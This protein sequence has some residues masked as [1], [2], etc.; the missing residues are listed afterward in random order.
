M[1]TVFMGKEDGKKRK[2]ITQQY[3]SGLYIAIYEENKPIPVQTTSTMREVDYHRGLRKKIPD[4]IRL[5]SSEIPDKTV[6]IFRKFFGLDGDD[7]IAI[8]PEIQ[9]NDNRC[10]CQSYQHIGQ[11]GPASYARSL[12]RPLAPETKF[13][14]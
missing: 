10:D 7:V 9:A 13:Q 6:V 1:Q 2:V 5:E 4:Y 3:I 11:H 14:R 8:F 12:L